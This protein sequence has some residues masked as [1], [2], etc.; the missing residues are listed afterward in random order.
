M[1]HANSRERN[2]AQMNQLTAEAKQRLGPLGQVGWLSRQPPE[3]QAAIARLGRWREFKPGEVIYF[4]G[5]E[6]DG[7]YGLAE[8]VLQMSFPL[9]GEE[10]VVVHRAEPG[11]WIGEAAILAGQTRFITLVAAT[12]ARVLFLPKVELQRMIDADPR[13]WRAFY[14]QSVTNQILTVKL[15]AEVLSLTPRARVARLMLRLA[16]GD[17]VVAGNQEDLARLLGMTRSSIRRALGSLV[18]NGVVSSGYGKL[19]IEDRDRLAALTTE[20]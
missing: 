19:V 15:I 11:F 4:Y 7:L 13:H 9:V 16:D 1:K 10:E 8:G 2:L 6:P 20:A 14:E 18:E 3:F 12:A 17:G 5:D